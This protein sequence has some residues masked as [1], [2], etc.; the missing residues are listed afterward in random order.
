MVYPGVTWAMERNRR[1][2]LPELGINEIG[3]DYLPFWRDKRTQFGYFK[4]YAI[5][6]GTIIV[7]KYLKANIISCRSE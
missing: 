5:G 4:L 7:L 1:I 6:F 3:S 2:V